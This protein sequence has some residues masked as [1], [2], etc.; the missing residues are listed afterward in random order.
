MTKYSGNFGKLAA[1]YDALRPSYPKNVISIIFASIK[2]R[3]PVILDL[4]CGT[5]IS[6]RQL[7]KSKASVIGCDIDKSMLKIARFS[8]K[9]NIKY[10]QGYA[11]KLPFENN[12]FDSVT[13]FIAF[14]WFMNKKAIRQIKRVLKPNGILCIVQPRFMPFQKDYRMVLEKELR[15]KIPKRYK[16]SK[17]ILPFLKQSGFRVKRHVIKSNVKYTLNEYIELLKSYSLW[18]FVPMGRRKEIE[19]LLK[20]HFQSKLVN[21][22][23]RNIKDI[24]VIV[25]K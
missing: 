25:A 9:L 19:S 10:V 22:Y 3:T 18:N 8:P 14:H 24:E 20:S 23:I 16:Q 1:K 7:T 17:E 21:G 5:G 15:H 13:T 2:S 6:T 11:E 4:G 12:K